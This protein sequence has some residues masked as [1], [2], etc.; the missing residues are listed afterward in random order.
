VSSLNKR[1]AYLGIADFDYLSA[2]ILLRHGIVFTGLPKAADAFEKIMKLC[3]VLEAKITRNEELEPKDLKRFEHDLPKLLA[4]FKLRTGI[5]VTDSVDEYFAMLK[6]AAARR[7]PR[8][9]AL[10]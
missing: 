8:A 2:R 5:P 6:D 9:L 7:C 3:L 4:E 10:L 1:L